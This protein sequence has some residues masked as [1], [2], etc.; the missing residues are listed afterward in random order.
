M[1][2]LAAASGGGT[3]D[4]G[5]LVGV[6]ARVIRALGEVGVGLLTLAETI[7]PPIPSEV[8]L[9]LAGFLSQRGDMN[10]VFVFISATL[11]AYLGALLLYWLGRRIGE[12]RSIRLLSK[13]PL[14]DRDD[15][16]RAAGWFSRH[17]KSAVFFGRLLPGVRSLISLPAGAAKMS[18]V[19]FSVF[20]IAG[21]ALWNALLIGLGALLGTQYELIDQYSWVLDVLVYAA[22]AGVI[23]WLVIRRIRR[24]R[25]STAS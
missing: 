8:V 23:G 24:G 7:F 6:A 5:G 25:A 21:S 17:G 20:T 9:P 13:L 2:T 4:L 3:D 16:E 18:L 1:T 19:V 22:I 12:E 14:V 11:G 10:I 15:F